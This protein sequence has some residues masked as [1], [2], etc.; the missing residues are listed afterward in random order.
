MSSD[1]GSKLEAVATMSNSS[2]PSAAGG[3]APAGDEAGRSAKQNTRHHCRYQS[4]NCNFWIS[5]PG[6]PSVLPL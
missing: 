1:V 2:S 5:C 6:F 3:T 4:Q